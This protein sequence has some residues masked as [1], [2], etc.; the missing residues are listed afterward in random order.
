[1]PSR[2]R[3]MGEERFDDVTAMHRGAIPD[4]DQA[5]GHLAPQVRQEGDH[6]RRIERAVLTVE[7]PCALR[8]DGTEGREM[9]TGAPFPQDGCLA[10]RRVGA[11]DTRQG[12]EARF[13]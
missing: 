12:I 10:H 5:A 13:I 8:R 3:A 1:M 6:I 7:I 2:R 4:D 9:L 11:D